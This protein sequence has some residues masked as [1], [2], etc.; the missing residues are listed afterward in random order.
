MVDDP[1]GTGGQVTARTAHMV[2]QTRN[3]FPG[4][5]WACYSPRPGTRSDHPLG[6]ACDV[7]VGNQIGH[8]PSAEQVDYGWR[9]TD[10][11]ETNAET[12]GISY[13][14]W[15]G[16]I[17][18]TARADEGWQ[19]Y[20]GGGMHDPGNVTGGHFDHIHISVKEG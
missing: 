14:I 8:Y 11:L 18:S 13:L 19:P 17:W 6:R 9:L 2:V 16:Q 15:Q 5:G 4:T 3:A 1:T 12:L 20:G 7:T 10:W